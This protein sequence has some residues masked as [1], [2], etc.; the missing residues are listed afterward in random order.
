MAWYDDEIKQLK[1]AEKQARESEQ[2]QL[3][4]AKLFEA[5]APSVFQAVLDEVRTAVDAVNAAV[6]DPDRRLEVTA[7]PSSEKYRVSAPGRKVEFWLDSSCRSIQIQASSVDLAHG[8]P[9]SM[10]LTLD[11][12]DDVRVGAGDG[13]PMAAKAI[14]LPVLVG[15][16]RP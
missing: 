2:R 6:A 5:K 13:I 12:N 10:G 7:V 15:L 3:H 4:R 9:Q 8:A 14:L 11:A 1:E 16:H